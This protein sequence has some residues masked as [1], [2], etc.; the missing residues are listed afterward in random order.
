M[1]EELTLPTKIGI[2]IF[3]F[4]LIILLDFTII[5]FLFF[6]VKGINMIH[7]DEKKECQNCDTKYD[8]MNI[9]HG[10]YVPIA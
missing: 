4:I 3:I 9:Y 8:V 7:S 1:Y 2:L 5:N 6:F 10:N